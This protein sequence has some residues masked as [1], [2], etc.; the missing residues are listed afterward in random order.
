MVTRPRAGAAAP[1]HGVWSAGAG[2]QAVIVNG[3]EMRGI[4]GGECVRE[5]YERLREV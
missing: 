3:A 4:G 2:S 1:A 5:G